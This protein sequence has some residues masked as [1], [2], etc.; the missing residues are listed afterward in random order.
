MRSKT[1]NAALPECGRRTGE[2]TMKRQWLIAGVLLLLLVAGACSRQ[3]YPPEDAL[4]IDID[5]GGG[6]A[7]LPEYIE[8]INQEPAPLW[9]D[10]WTVTQWQ[11]DTYHLPTGI[12]L[13]PQERIRIWAG[14]G[15]D[16]D[17][18]LYAGRAEGYWAIN[19]LS[20]D[21]PEHTIY[22]SMSCDIGM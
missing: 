18:N 13:D 5:Y 21:N 4:A 9:L 1:D 15:T 12:T 3:I 6:E 20:L 2:K 22:W 19:G 11:T 10:G 8:I 17:E 7:C 16:D 14:A